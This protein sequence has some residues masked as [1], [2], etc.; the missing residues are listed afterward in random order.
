MY[1]IRSYYG[2]EKAREHLL[3]FLTPKERK[4]AVA[5]ESGGMKVLAEEYLL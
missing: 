2:Q 1:A 3:H 4:K 5:K